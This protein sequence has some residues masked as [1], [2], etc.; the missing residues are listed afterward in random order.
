MKFPGGSKNQNQWLQ[1]QGHS[2]SHITE[3]IEEDISAATSGP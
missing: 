3:L 1:N 2:P